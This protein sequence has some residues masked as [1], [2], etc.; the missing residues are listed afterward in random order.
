MTD[1]MTAASTTGS[2]GEELASVVRDLLEGHAGIDHLKERLDAG[3]AHAPDLWRRLAGIGLVSAL[4]A[5]EHGGVGLGPA[6]LAPTLVALGE[7]ALPEPFVETAVVGATVLGEF[8]ARDARAAEWLARLAAGDLLVAVAFEG[9]TGYVAYAADAD[10]LLDLRQDGSVRV[11]A[12]GDLVVEEQPAVDPL[13][14][15]ARVRPAGDGVLLG[16]SPELTER[17]WN[18]AVA[19]TAC[20]L[21]G[22]ARRLLT[23]T[24]EYVSLR[25]QF[26][27]PV[28][29]FQAVKHKLADIAVRADMAVTGA[30]DAVAASGA[31]DAARR[32]AVAKAYAGDAAERA[33]DEA[34]QLHGGIG[35][36]WEHHLHFW[37]KRALSLGAAYGSTTEHRRRLA[38]E[39]LESVAA[40]EAER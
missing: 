33:N 12:A 10:L 14:P 40:E 3:S 4:V 2:E 23:L 28:G 38:R 22:T 13:R 21:A 30:L 29:S 5:E 24:V 20:L 18:L 31:P 25:H 7:Y 8:A 11:H 26:G 37:L 36:T 15:I 35:F 39:L 34:L 32:A 6:D 27:R 9:R 1:T 16:R 19:S 17:A